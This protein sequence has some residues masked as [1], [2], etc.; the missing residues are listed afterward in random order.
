MTTVRQETER[1]GGQLIRIVQPGDTLHGI[2]FALGLNVNKLAAW[3]GIR[4]TSKL[5]VGQRIRLTEPI[6]FTSRP[7]AAANKPKA[8]AKPVTRSAARAVDKPAQKKPVKPVATPPSSAS[9]TVAS[10]PKPSIKTTSQPK[11]VVKS[12]GQAWRW[13][14]IGTVVGKFTA[15]RGHQGIDIRATRGQSVTAAKPGEIVYVGNS[16]KG[17]GNLIIIKH[18]EE[19]L[20]AYAHNQDIYVREG[21]TVRSQQKIA[22][23]GVNNQRIAALHFQI[24]REGQPVD[25]LKHLPPR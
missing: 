8:S 15:G 1:L 11:A 21:Q 14:T 20:S 17:Y 10:K 18:D 12:G 23:V 2:S 4:D 6:G 3:N 25:P 19:F 13:P 22:T 5:Q 7:V 24:R 9:K 16:L